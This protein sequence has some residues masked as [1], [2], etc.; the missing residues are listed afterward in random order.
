MTILPDLVLDV[1][2]RSC[3]PLKKSGAHR[4]SL[5]PTTQVFIACYG[6]TANQIKRW[7]P[8]TEP[9]PYDLVTHIAD[10]GKIV[11]HNA[12]FERV[13]WNNTVR[14]DHPYL[15]PMTIEQMSCTMVRAFACNLPGKLEQLLKVLG[16]PEKDMSGHAVMQR[17]TRPRKILANGDVTWWDDEER[18]AVVEDYCEQDVYSEGHVHTT[19]PELTPDELELWRLDQYINERGVPIDMQFVNRAAELVDYAKNRAHEEIWKLTGGEVGKTT[20]VQGLVRWLNK[21]GVTTGSLRAGDR[22]RLLQIAEFLGDDTAESVIETRVTGAKTSTA[23]YKAQQWTVCPDNYERGSLQYGGAQ[24]TL[25]WAGRLTQKQNYPRVADD[26]EAEVVNWVVGL[27]KD[28]TRPLAEIYD[29]IELI[30]PPNLANGD[31]QDGL[32][33]LAWMAKSLRSTIAA[34][35]DGS[36]LI[37][38]DFSNIEG[39]VNAWLADE[40][41]KLEA[42]RAYDRGEGPDLYNLAFAKSFNVPVEMVTRP[43]RQIG[44]VEELA[45][46]YQGGV[47]AFVT[48]VNTYLIKLISLAKAIQASTP[49]SNGMLWQGV[50]QGLQTSLILTRWCGQRS[51]WRWLAG[52]KPT[53]RLSPT[54]GSYKT[55]PSQQRCTLAP[56]FPST[57][58]GVAMYPT[59]IFFTVLF[60]AAGRYSIASRTSS[61]KPAL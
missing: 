13:I 1:E 7:R 39:R 60:P 16:L 21:R 38:G 40:H 25:R 46:G 54:G 57:G 37:G 50:T 9:P 17:I 29:L 22:A 43:Q 32:A 14:R 26:N 41:W 35:D 4:Y 18:V 20:D 15:P 52:V 31:K 34:P 19:L 42:F 24:Q 58:A 8:L 44:K 3:L 2:T 10:G 48:M 12:Q 33:T 56:L 49:Q 28:T 61:K 27:T 30:G 5:D 47:G 11:A 51:S 59:R 45:C 53:H 55:R 23:K 36:F 6:Y